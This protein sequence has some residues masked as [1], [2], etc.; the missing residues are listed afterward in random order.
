MT[1]TTLAIGGALGAA[2]VAV[3][4]WKLTATVPE[5]SEDSPPQPNVLWIVWDTVRSDRLSAYDPS[6]ET[7]PKLAEW[8]RGA[9]VYEDVVSVAHSTLPAHAS[10]FTG[11]TTT[12]HDTHYSHPRLDDRY[13]TIAELLKGAG[14]DT[15]MWSSNPHVSHQ[16]NMHQGFDTV[17]HPWDGDRLSEAIEI[18]RAKVVEDRGTGVAAALEG[19][20]RNWAIKAS[21]ELAEPNLV[22]WLDDREGEQP[23]FAFLNYMEAHRQYIPARAYRERFMTPEQV[24]RSYTI[25]QSWLT[26]WKYVFGLYEYSDEDMAIIRATYDATLAELDDIF[27]SLL[28]TLR[29]RGDLENTIVILTADHGEHLGEHHLVDHQFT[30]F[31]EVL[32]VPLIVHYPARF[33]P[34][35]DESPVSNGDVFPTLLE[36]AGV[37]PPELPSPM[38][39]LLHPEEGRVRI[40]EH[41]VPHLP[42]INLVRRVEPSVNVSTMAVSM[43]AIYQ[44]G[45]KLIYREGIPNWVFDVVADPHE[46]HPLESDEIESA[47]VAQLGAFLQR[48]PALPPAPEPPPPELDEEQ[49]EALRSLGYLESDVPPDIPP[50][51]PEA[52]SPER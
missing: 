26:V 14:Y 43:C 50:E 11:L 31:E 45:R 2:I 8:A 17:Q 44:G 4:I 35:R 27:A 24:A 9:R 18:V 28:E 51:P 3:V 42:P 38:V 32:R 36:L 39:S 49:R 12:Q 15:Y 1:R 52:P 46:T 10:M 7:T 37:A 6:L 40:A 13:D 41:P 22:R 47:L 21:G 48:Y 20:V 33:E 19:Q 16:T 29:E 25:D 23:Y 34:G 5:P 30:V